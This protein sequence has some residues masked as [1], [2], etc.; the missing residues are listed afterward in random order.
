MVS[1]RLDTLGEDP[2]RK[3]ETICLIAMLLSKQ[4]PHE[5]SLLAHH[6]GLITGI[7]CKRENIKEEGWREGEERAT[8]GLFPVFGGFLSPR[9]VP[10]SRANSCGRCGVLS[11][12]PRL[13]VKLEAE[14]QRM[15][16]SSR[17]AKNQP[18]PPPRNKHK[19]RLIEN[20]HVRREFWINSCLRL[21]L[22]RTHTIPLRGS[23]ESQARLDQD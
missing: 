10:G 13:L 18:K 2:K 12:E 9:W 4:N 1:A 5:I 7:V 20:L 23:G 11:K 16:H 6:S 19:R 17:K 15:S 14:N 22:F 21:L 3:K 8:T